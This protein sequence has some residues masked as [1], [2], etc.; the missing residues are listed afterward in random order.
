MLSGKAVS[1]AN[2]AHLLTESALIIK[3]QRMSLAENSQ[4]I[5]DRATKVDLE[6][7][8][9]IYNA[10]VSKTENVNT[11]K[12]LSSFLEETKKYITDRV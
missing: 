6:E 7:I 1:R 10:V 3:L 9:D 12:T 11:L 4:S 2:R 5:Q 8:K